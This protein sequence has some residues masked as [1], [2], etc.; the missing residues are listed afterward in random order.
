MSHLTTGLPSGSDS[1]RRD[2]LLAIILASAASLGLC[3]AFAFGYWVRGLIDRDAGRSARAEPAPVAA[4]SQ[5]A[6]AVDP[7]AG[8]A[9]MA[10]AESPRPAREI[11]PTDRP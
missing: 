8:P 1:T 10:A 4:A 9:P 3:S 7:A 6:V 2:V 11:P 5:P